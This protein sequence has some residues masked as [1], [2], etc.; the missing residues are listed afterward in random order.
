VHGLGLL[1]K[2]AANGRAYFYHYDGDGNVVALS[3][4]AA[5]IVNRYRYDPLGRLI[6]TDE[7]VENGFRARGEAGVVD[8]G[9]GLLCGDGQYVSPDLRVAFNGTIDIRPP[10][11][12]L[13]PTLS[14]PGMCLLKGIADCALAGVRRLQ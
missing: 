14:P 10:V 12:D 8:D 7:T 9:N 3:N 13:Y 5:G 1:W 11:P 2:V 4:P 6:G